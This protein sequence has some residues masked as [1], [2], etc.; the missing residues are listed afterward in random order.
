MGYAGDHNLFV[1]GSIREH[2][3][4]DSGL[5]LDFYK[6]YNITFHSPK[7]YFGHVADLNPEDFFLCDVAD[8]EF[9]NA[10]R[11]SDYVRYTGDLDGVTRLEN[12]DYVARCPDNR[13]W[14]AP[15][16]RQNSSNCIPLLAAGNGW[17][18]DAMMQWYS[19][20]E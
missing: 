16:C 13:F 11:M 1:K 10:Q 17:I 18:V 14:L 6:N 2:A 7:R 20:H 12:G 9:R 4:S 8:L 5:A 19:G 3:Y 15:T